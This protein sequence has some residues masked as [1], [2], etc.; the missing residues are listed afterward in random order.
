MYIDSWVER[1][2]NRNLHPYLA[3]WIKKFQD[4]FLEE[5]PLENAHLGKTPFTTMG[6][7]KN[8]ECNVQMMT[9]YIQSLHG[10]SKVIIFSFWVILEIVLSLFSKFCC[11]FK[12]CLCRIWQGI[13]KE[14]G[15]LVFKGFNCFSNP[16]FETIILLQSFQLKNYTTNVRD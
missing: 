1:F 15:S 6:V 16:N 10:S 14:V 8:D 12:L 3:S 4:V 5:L 13:E 11:Q 7:I 9:F 2:I